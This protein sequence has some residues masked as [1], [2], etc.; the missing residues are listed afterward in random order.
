[1]AILDEKTLDFISTSEA[2][3]VRLGVRLGELLQKGD[4]IC[5]SGELGAGK[6]TFVRGVGRGWGAGQRV[7]SPTFVLVNQYP[8]LQ[9][10]MVLYHLDGYRLESWGEVV[11]TGMEDLFAGTSCAVIEWAE[12][13]ERMLPPDRL[14]LTFRYISDTRRGVRMVAF[15]ERSLALLKAFRQS[16]FGV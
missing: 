2:Q 11:T 6:T 12:R 13:I 3:T 4:V 14:W 7:T 16:A 5:L 8:R 15:G 1:M 9:D 10:G